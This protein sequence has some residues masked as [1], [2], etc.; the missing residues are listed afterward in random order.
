MSIYN[1]LNLNSDQQKIKVPIKW[2]KSLIK[3]IKV[4][5]IKK[6]TLFSSSSDDEQ[7]PE[8][9]KTPEEQQ[10]PETPETIDPIKYNNFSNLVTQKEY[11]NFDKFQIGD[12]L[13]KIKKYNDE[14]I[15]FN[16]EQ[17]IDKIELLGVIINNNI[18]F[19]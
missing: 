19:F 10:T 18:I 14:F 1:L 8:T 13:V 12:R 17:N 5:S 16:N 7:T 9:I 3:L 11:D 4:K 15:I 2:D 6:N